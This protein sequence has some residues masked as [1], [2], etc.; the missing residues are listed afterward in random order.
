MNDYFVP[1]QE[2]RQAVEARIAMFEAGIKRLQKE[3][4]RRKQPETLKWAVPRFEYDTPGSGS[5]KY[6]GFD[7]ASEAY[8]N[9]YRIL[10]TDNPW[11][12]PE[13]CERIDDYQA[14]YKVEKIYV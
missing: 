14:R 11:Y 13:H 7:T 4:A 9:A 1:H 3:L 12:D 8:D 6:H 5:V 10:V 2:P